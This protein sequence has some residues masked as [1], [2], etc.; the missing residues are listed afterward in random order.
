MRAVEPGAC[1][2]SRPLGRCR[3]VGAINPA[4][5]RE[6]RQTSVMRLNPNRCRALVL[7]A[8]S[9]AGFP[10]ELMQAQGFSVELV[11]NLIR[12][13]HAAIQGVRS[14]DGMP[15]IDVPRIRITGA[16]LAALPAAQRRRAFRR[17]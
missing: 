11:E 15:V 14:L 2:K 16:G 6:S 8:S 12:D 13:G 10:R 17:K 7:L 9:R 1:S 3:R 5:I 4:L